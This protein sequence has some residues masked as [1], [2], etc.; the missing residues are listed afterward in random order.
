MPSVI[1]ARLD[2]ASQKIMQQLVKKT[3][4]NPSKIIREGLRVLAA[5]H[6]TKGKRTIGGQGKFASGV[7]DLAS[8]K[9]YLR[10]FGR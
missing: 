1:Q 2:S 6:V 3:G 10:D 8:N 7:G 9:G 5:C 4:W